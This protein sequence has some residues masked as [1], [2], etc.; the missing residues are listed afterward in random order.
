[1]SDE[2]SVKPSSIDGKYLKEALPI[3]LFAC[4][5]YVVFLGLIIL[6]AGQL[7]FCVFSGNKNK[8]LL[9]LSKGLSAYLTK[10]INYISFETSVKPM[11]N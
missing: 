10:I 8:S 2:K 11:P 6:S 5:G 4:I 9:E 3:I 1:M 7:L